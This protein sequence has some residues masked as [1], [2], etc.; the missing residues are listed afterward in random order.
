VGKKDRKIARQGVKEQQKGN[1]I[2][3]SAI[4]TSVSLAL[5]FW[6]FFSDGR[7]SN[8]TNI[9]NIYVDVPERFT[10]TATFVIPA[11]HTEAMGVVDGML[12]RDKAVP[13]DLLLRI[14][15]VEYVRGQV[16]NARRYFEEALRTSIRD[17]NREAQ[18]IALNSLGMVLQY[19]G[20][21]DSALY[22]HAEAS[23][24]AAREGFRL[25]ESSSEANLGLVEFYRGNLDAGLRHHR[26]S[27][28]IN[29]EIGNRSGEAEDLNNIGLIMRDRRQLD[30]AL[31][32]FDRALDIDR[33]IGNRPGQAADLTNIAVIHHDFDSVDLSMVTFQ[34]ALQLAKEIPYAR[35]VGIIQ[36]NLGCLYERLGDTTRAL[37]YLDSAAEVLGQCVFEPASDHFTSVAAKLRAGSGIGP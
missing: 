33:E 14:G 8:I 36:G 18:V 35:Y 5:V 6:I 25:G 12:E 31:D 22:V 20:E 21:L 16:E 37:A 28:D 9:Y 27:L 11:G 32:Y 24:V 34:E 17:S 29:R 2:A 13:P 3:I 1:R 7:D 4:A 15:N 30:S 19:C 10:K 23:A 26:K